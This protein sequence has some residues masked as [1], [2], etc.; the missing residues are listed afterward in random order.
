MQQEDDKILKYP[1]T[2]GQIDINEENNLPDER[3]TEPQG[4]FDQNYTFFLHYSKLYEANSLLKIE[5]Q[6]LI[7]EKLQLKQYISK[8]EVY[9][10]Y[11]T[12]N[13]EKK[14]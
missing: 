8:I 5:L 14:R 2:K 4:L 1:S 3:G 13:L 10:K 7:R 11:F 9:M 12:F 6:N